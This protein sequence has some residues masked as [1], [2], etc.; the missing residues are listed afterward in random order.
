MR[1]L[2]DAVEVLAKSLGCRELA[3]DASI[4]SQTSDVV[5]L[6]LGFRET[7]RVMRCDKRV[8]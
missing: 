6:R 1:H 4:R 7:E 2:V 3:S 8:R 5:H